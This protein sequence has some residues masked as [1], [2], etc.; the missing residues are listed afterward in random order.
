MSTAPYDNLERRRELLRAREFLANAYAGRGRD[1][2]VTAGNV[3]AGDYD[4]SP[5][6]TALLDALAQSRAQD[7]AP[8]GNYTKGV[9]NDERACVNCYLGESPCLVAQDSGGEAALSAGERKAIEALLNTAHC[10][11]CIA[12]DTE[13]SGGECL[14]VPRDGFDQLSDALDALDTL[15]DDQP[16][17]T[18]D[19][20]AK[21]RWAL[22]RLLDTAAEQPAKGEGALC[23][24]HQAGCNFPDCPCDVDD[25][26]VQQPSDPADA[27]ET[28]QQVA[29]ELEAIDVHEL[30]GKVRLVA[31]RLPDSTSPAQRPEGDAVR[32]LPEK[33]LAEAVDLRNGDDW[34]RAEEREACA[35]ELE[36]ALSTPPSA[37]PQAGVVDDR[38]AKYQELIMAVARKFPG[39]SRH[40]TALRYIQRA[41]SADSSRCSAALAPAA[42]EGS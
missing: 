24:V 13:D 12:D 15:P 33:W 9:C 36:A 41:E 34:K 5:Q 7:S 10:A 16:G 38:L 19:A 25:P 18:M 35:S 31:A 6:M 30:A 42:G 32:R 1:W 14:S 17:Y 27:V 22:R 23:E 40:E 3:R 2:E 4:D 11:W 39:E 26:L 37:E 29:R 21:A 28:L 8:S 20:A